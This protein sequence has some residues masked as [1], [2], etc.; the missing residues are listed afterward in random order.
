MVFVQGTVNFYDLEELLLNNHSFFLRTVT[1]WDFF[2]GVRDCF[3]IH[4]F[5]IFNL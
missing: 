4:Y 5:T 3:A 2:S 1:K